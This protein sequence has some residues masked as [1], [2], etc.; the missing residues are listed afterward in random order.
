M[1]KI[2]YFKTRNGDIFIRCYNKGLSYT[3]IRSHRLDGSVYKSEV[4]K[5]DDLYFNMMRLLGRQEFGYKSSV[6][7][8]P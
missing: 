8:I 7:P 5:G 2:A 6:S 3:I 4:K 1:Q